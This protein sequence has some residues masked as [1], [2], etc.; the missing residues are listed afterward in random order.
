MGIR[1]TAKALIVRD[2]KLLLNRCYDVKNGEYY[3][4]PGGGQNQYETIY[5]AV[6]RECLEET[7]YTVK[8]VKFAALFEE[9]CLNAEYRY[10]YPDYAHKMYHIFICELCE[11]TKKNPTEIDSMQVES[12]WIN[13]DTLTR[14]RILPKVVGDNIYE[15]LSNP[16]PMFLGSEQV[17]FNHG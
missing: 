12:V 17:E 4:M 13:I 14:F 16:E 5:D 7:G 6:T 9:I 3:S 8:P 11:N 2:G 1:S 15:I 10:K